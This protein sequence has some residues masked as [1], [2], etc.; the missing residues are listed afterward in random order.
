MVLEAFLCTSQLVYCYESYLEEAEI[1]FNTRTIA[2]PLIVPKF[3]PFLI[4]F[5]NI[6]V[7]AINNTKFRIHESF[8][9]ESYFF[10][11]I[12]KTMF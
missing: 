5:S 7:C 9:L 2:P 12:L 11:E 8:E 6:F 4:F 10:I 3:D 1:A